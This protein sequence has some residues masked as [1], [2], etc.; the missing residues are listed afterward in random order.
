MTSRAVVRQL[1]GVGDD[2]LDVLFQ[3]ALEQQRAVADLDAQID[4]G[5][6]AAKLGEQRRQERAGGKGAGAEGRVAH[7][8]AAEEIDVALERRGLEQQL[9]RALENEGAGRRR[10]DLRAA[11][12]QPQPELGLGRL[13]ASRQGGLA[14]VHLLGGPGEVAGLGDGDDVG[15]PLEIH[16][17]APEALKSAQ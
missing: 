13:H 14:E 16:V 3:Q 17:D 7:L 15:Q 12:E 10:R 1:L 2:E 5:M 9:P 4:T 11:V 6:L 8:L